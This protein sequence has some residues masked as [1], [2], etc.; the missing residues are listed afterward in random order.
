MEGNPMRKWRT[1]ITPSPAEDVASFRLGIVGDLLTQELV[2]GELTREL[3]ARALKRYRRPGAET[4]HRY[5]Y[6]TLQ[7]WYLAAKK[8]LR[9]LAPRSRKRGV[10]LNLTDRQR[11]ILLDVRQEHPNASAELVLSEGIR[12]GVVDAGQISVTTLRRLYRARGLT[13]G[14]HNRTDRRQRRRWAAARV[15]AVWHADVCHVFVRQPDGTRKRILVHAIV[16][17]HSRFV[18]AIE[19]RLGETENDMLAL[20]CAALMRHPRPDILYLDNGSTYSGKVLA[21]LC[22]R[23][24]IRLVHAKPYDPRARGKM[25]R[26]WSSMRGQCTDFLDIASLH[27]VNA[28]VL[29]WT[30]RYHRQ[31]HAGLLGQLPRKRYL[32]GVRKLGAPLTAREIAL[33]L[34]ITVTRR[35]RGDNTLSLEGRTFEVTGRHLIGRTI[36]VVVDPFTDLPI[37]ARY[38]DRDVPVAI[39]DPVANGRRTRAATADE[40]AARSSDTSAY[41]A[42][43]AGLLAAARREV[44]DG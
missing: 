37:R 35:V 34:E 3:K 31:P 33:A 2:P 43:I 14:A 38:D 39:C 20:L 15:G 10:A 4:T 11:Q 7:R 24:G 23:L 6:K 44:D 42:P 28:A 1:L 19:A 32:D 5:H 16:D 40:G 26:L 17:D 36:H 21:V 13:R 18:V 8:D 27:D 41:F 9:G 25:E 29:A 22:Q 30:D 12:N